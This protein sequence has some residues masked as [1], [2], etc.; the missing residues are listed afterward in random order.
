MAVLTPL[1]LDEAQRVAHAHGLSCDALTP[2]AAGSVNSNFVIEGSTRAFLRIYEEQ[3]V[4]GVAYEW[5]LL[6]H[7]SAAGV[8]TARRLG[9]VAPGEVRVAGKCTAVFEW[10][11]GE[12][13]CQR[14]F[15]AERARAL[16]IA[17]ARAHRAGADFGW[18]R[19][20]RFRRADVVARMRAIPRDAELTPVLERL[21]RTR[22]EVDAR[23]PRDLPSG[24]VHGDLFRDNLLW[25]GERVAAIIDWESASDHFFMYDL[26]V[27]VLAWCMGDALDW[28]LARTLVAGY[29]SEREPSEAEWAA[30]GVL[31]RS[32]ALRF[33]V[34][35]ITDFH[36]RWG[37]E[38][39][40]DY[41]R[42]VARLDAL[43]QLSND[44]LRERV[45]APAREA[46]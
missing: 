5:A 7:L 38:A 42:F 23:W 3:S 33:S 24:V 26:A 41:R 11:A 6:D 29:R 15:G 27:T 43:E 16:G 46:G 40:K 39:P 8:P 12:M 1:A 22:V 28:E 44:A 4:D 32:A 37:A 30:F 17:V 13:S 34:T 9:A 19:R 35:R 36:L 10:A 18:R 25:D 2:I 20:G 31:A 14:A 21:E 45:G